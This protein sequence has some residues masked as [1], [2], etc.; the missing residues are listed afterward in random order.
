MIRNM[1]FLQRQKY[2][3]LQTKMSSYGVEVQPSY[4]RFEKGLSSGVNHYEMA[5]EPAATDTVTEKK[6]NKN[7]AFYVTNFLF[8]YIVNGSV[9]VNS[10]TLTLDSSISPIQTF[11]NVKN[12]C[13]TLESLYNG[14]LRITTGSKIN[15]ENWSTQNFKYVPQSVQTGIGSPTEYNLEDAAAST[16]SDLLLCGTKSHTIAFDFPAIPVSS[17]FP[18]IPASINYD[19]TNMITTSGVSIML[20]LNGF[21]LKNGAIIAQQENFSL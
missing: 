8:G 16:I 7:D 19:G 12:G 2:D 6:L 14:F 9:S 15:I 11:A 4:L 17:D 20:Q 13:E 1:N 21:L 18:L 10:K 5:W 3:E